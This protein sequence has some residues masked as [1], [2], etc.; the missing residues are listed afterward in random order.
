MASILRVIPNALYEKLIADGIIQKEFSTKSDEIEQLLIKNI[1]ITLH[2]RA[3][4]IIDI[5]K[6]CSSIHWNDKFEVIKD[7]NTIP[8]SDMRD[9]LK[10]LVLQ[11]SSF[12]DLP[13][14]TEIRDL[15][16]ECNEQQFICKLPP[17]IKVTSTSDIS[18]H[19]N[20]KS[21]EE[22]FDNNE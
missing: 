8:F 4:D 22:I 14:S 10:Y 12:Y 7:N 17:N 19:C 1:P 9:L 18:H 16:L 15:L 20:W 6:K 21:F 3:K 2:D 5:I 13:G 11:Q